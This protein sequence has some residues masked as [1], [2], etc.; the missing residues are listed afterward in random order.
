[1]CQTIVSEF[2]WNILSGKANAT[3]VWPSDTEDV[4]EK[5]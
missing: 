4:D 2:E 3:L 5:I 1:M